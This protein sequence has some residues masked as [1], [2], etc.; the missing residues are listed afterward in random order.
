MVRGT[1]CV[2]LKEGMYDPEGEKVKEALS[3]LGFNNIAKVRVGKLYQIELNEATSNV[4]PAVCE[5]LLVNPV[6]ERYEI[7]EIE[8]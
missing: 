1:V 6:I 5:A 7:R 2:Y 8:E 4:I 3:L